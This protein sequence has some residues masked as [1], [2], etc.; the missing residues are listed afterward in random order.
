MKIFEHVDRKSFCKTL[1]LIFYLIFHSYVY[2]PYKGSTGKLIRPVFIADM[3]YVVSSGLLNLL[4]CIRCENVTAFEHD[5]N[6]SHCPTLEI[7]H[8]WKLDVFPSSSINGKSLYL[9]GTIRKS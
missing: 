9:V 3:V 5:Y 8:F 7:F 4:N 6:F 2:M 1:K